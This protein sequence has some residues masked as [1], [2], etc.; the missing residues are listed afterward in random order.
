MLTTLLLAAAFQ[1]TPAPAATPAAEKPIC[2]REV[3]MGSNMMRKTCH[4]RAEWARIDGENA[5][6]GER[7]LG[8]R[9]N[10]PGG[11]NN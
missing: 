9:V 3:P 2:R 4:T 8:Q 6:A 1:T 11:G 5:G 10:R 7:A